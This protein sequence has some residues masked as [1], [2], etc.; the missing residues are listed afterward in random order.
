MHADA[1][2]AGTHG[3]RGQGAGGQ[4]GLVAGEGAPEVPA[5]AE[6]RKQD[7]ERTLSRWLACACSRTKK[8]A[9]ISVS[10]R[11]KDRHRSRGSYLGIPA[12]A[13][14]HLCVGYAPGKWKGL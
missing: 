13:C 10:V 14:A 2:K 3:T 1:G 4:G 7:G 11:L 8:H 6:T 9:A 5:G 12:Q